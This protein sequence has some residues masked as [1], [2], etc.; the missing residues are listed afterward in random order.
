MRNIVHSAILT[1]ALAVTMLLGGC[2][3]DTLD[4]YHGSDYIHF[5]PM[6]NDDA[7]RTTL[8]FATY[9]STGE[10][11]GRVP[12]SVTLWGYL[13]EADFRYEVSV[14]ADRTTASSSDYTAPSHGTFHAGRA[15]DTLWITVRRNE[16]LLATDYKFTLRMESADGYVIGPNMDD[17][18]EVS[19]VDR[20]DKPAWWEQAY[21]VRLGAYSDVKYRV[22]NIYLGR[23]L[24]S[25][26]GY[27]A[28]TL[29]EEITR[30]KAWWRE[31]W[32]AGEYRYYDEDG[33]TPLYET[34]ADAA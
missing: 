12:V 3:E 30:F 13:P 32:E 5:T 1:A 17:T 18:A 27:T 2:K 24:T 14:V 23:V 33:T 22:L 25:L 9:G 16:R 20:I 10:S 7:Q 31:R 11:S 28:I 8:N 19:V 4:V 26:D 34:I 21:A 6:A 15:V 29:G